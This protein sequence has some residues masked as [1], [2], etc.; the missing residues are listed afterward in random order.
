M[1]TKL[2]LNIRTKKKRNDING[3]VLLKTILDNLFVKKV[4]GLNFKFIRV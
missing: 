2:H 1:V 3:R 4:N